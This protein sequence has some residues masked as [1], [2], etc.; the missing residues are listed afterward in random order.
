M[1]KPFRLFTTPLLLIA[2]FLSNQ[3]YAQQ[4]KDATSPKWIKMMDDRN[5]NFF[6][7]QKE[8]NS[9]WKDK[10]KP[11]EEK[12]VFS[13]FEKKNQT[14]VK[15]NEGAEAKK[16]SFEYKRF[17]NWQREVAPYVQPDGRILNTEERIKLWEQE[18]KNREAGE[19]KADS[20]RTDNK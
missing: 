7:A 5:V 15:F 2:I 4:K 14:K 19:Q 18:K 3:S 1:K 8:F 6:E 13:N 11:T 12:E 10:E 20:S 9:F 16:Y 17:L